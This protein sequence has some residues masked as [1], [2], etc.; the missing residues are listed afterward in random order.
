MNKPM[1]ETDAEREFLLSQLSP[2]DRD[3]VENFS[4]AHDPSAARA[5]EM[6]GIGQAD[7]GSERLITETT[8]ERDFLLSQFVPARPRAS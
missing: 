6:L 3:R 7:F 4:Q 8:E 1:I 2:E 5:I